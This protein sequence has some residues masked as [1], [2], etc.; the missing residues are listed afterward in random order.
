MKLNLEQTKKLR[1]KVMEKYLEYV[2][3]HYCNNNI[4]YET[5]V[6]NIYRKLTFKLLAYAGTNDRF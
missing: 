4:A 2:E 5:R 1:E 6:A 3:T